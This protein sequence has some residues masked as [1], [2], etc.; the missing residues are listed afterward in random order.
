M[1]KLFCGHRLESG[2]HLSLDSLLVRDV[3]LEKCIIQ[4]NNAT[5]F[6]N[7]EL[8][9]ISF[10]VHLMFLVAVY[11][12]MSLTFIWIDYQ[13]NPVLEMFANGYI[14]IVIT[15]LNCITKIFVTYLDSWWC[16]PKYSTILSMGQMGFCWKNDIPCIATNIVECLVKAPGPLCTKLEWAFTW[17]NLSDQN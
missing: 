9:F 4:I 7:N 14:N 1:V 2:G 11:N 6:Q 17:T 12:K 5:W 10:F 3:I 16:I 8:Q 13:S 15:Y